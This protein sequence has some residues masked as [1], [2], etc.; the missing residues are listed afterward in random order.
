MHPVKPRRIGL[1]GDVGSGKSTVRRWLA[2]QGAA[3]VDADAVVH[4]LLAE[5]SALV[6]GIG[7]RFGPAVL[8]PEGGVDRAALA[9]R[10]FADAA[11]RA[12]LESVL[13]PAVRQRI[14]DW[15]E[16]QAAPLQVVE[17]LFL[18]GSPVAAVLDQVWLV[19][20][21]S[22]ARRAR[23]EERGWDAATIAA[24]MAAAPPLAPRLAAADQI[25][26]NSGPWAATE[27]QL[28]RA[29]AQLKGGP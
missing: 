19:M 7:E 15:L 25:I 10:V 20:A 13:H 26:D 8:R 3:T 17:A 24:R 27:A 23:L 18:L 16:A 2:E 11:D 29:L 9:T 6:A 22:E 21:D 14:L 4:E 28:R 12:W 5:P 1:T